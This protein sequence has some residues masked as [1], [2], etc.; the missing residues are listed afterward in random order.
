M[1]PE[2]SQAVE[3]GHVDLHVHSILD[4]DSVIRIR[5]TAGLLRDS[6][7]EDE[8]IESRYPTLAPCFT[9]WREIYEDAFE[10]QECNLGSG[11]E[12]FPNVELRVAWYTEGF[13][14]ACWLV[15]Q[16]GVDSVEF[17]SVGKTYR[18]DKAS[19]GEKLKEFLDETDALLGEEQ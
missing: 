19:V 9:A 14:M 2:I 17:A 5:L 15:L 7:V 4:P 6:A 1:W 8:V 11:K 10:E 18:L 13:L 12:V 16:P 3:R